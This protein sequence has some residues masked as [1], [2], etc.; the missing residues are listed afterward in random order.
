MLTSGVKSSPNA[1][2]NSIWLLVGI[3]NPLK[4]KVWWME[5]E[6]SKY[7]GWLTADQ[8]LDVTNHLMV[9]AGVMLLSICLLENAAIIS[10]A[11]ISID[12]FIATL[13]AFLALFWGPLL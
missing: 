2:F 10:T 3:W 11:L 1:I 9:L 7:F 4:K 13:L 8:I 12:G 6:A 5:I